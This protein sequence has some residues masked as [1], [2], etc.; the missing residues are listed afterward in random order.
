MVLVHKLLSV[1]GH[2]NSASE[3]AFSWHKP[4][5]ALRDNRI[6]F[7]DAVAYMHQKTYNGQY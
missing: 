7:A 4:Q 3:A 5:Y 2:T 6:N 1:D